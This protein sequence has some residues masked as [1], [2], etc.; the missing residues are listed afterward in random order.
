M[1]LSEWTLVASGMRSDVLGYIAQPHCNTAW[2]DRS[3]SSFPSFSQERPGDKDKSAFDSLYIFY[4]MCLV[5]LMQGSR[6]HYQ[7]RMSCVSC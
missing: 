3:R 7:P 6:L 5:S 1:L 2:V 4:G